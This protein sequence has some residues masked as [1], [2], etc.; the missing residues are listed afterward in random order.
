MIRPAGI[1]T[2]HNTFIAEV[3]VSVFS[4]GHFSNNL[5]I[6]PDDDRPT[7]LV[8]SL[9][10]YSTFDYN[11]Y[12]KKS[13]SSI[14]YRLRYPL[15]IVNNNADEKELSFFEFKTLNE[16]KK[17]T[18]FE[19]HGLELDDDT[20]QNVPLPDP[21]IK[22]HIYPVKGYDFRLKSGSR[23]IDAGVAL[24]NINDVYSGKAPD[25]GAIEF[26]SEVIKYGPR[27]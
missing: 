21:K 6:G 15:T 9:T 1:Y 20:F 2:Y 5:F 8:T 10:T 3:A 22:G 7:L 16:F 11:G 17:K 13:G 14:K 18:G 27:D 12:R 24:P 4:N 25:V 26:G 19:M 23:A